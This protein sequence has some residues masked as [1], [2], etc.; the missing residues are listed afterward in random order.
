MGQ[1]SNVKNM[2]KYFDGKLSRGFVSIYSS[3]I[4]L[5]ISVA[6]LGLFLPIFMFELFGFSLKYVLIYYL[7]DYIIYGLIVAPGAKISLNKIG[8]KKSIIIS[9]FF[10]MI[11]YFLF[12][13]VDKFA[14]VGN[15]NWFSGVDREKIIIFA[16]LTI[17]IINIRRV[18]Y[19]VPIHTDL[20]KFTDRK[21]RLKQ[22]SL[23]EASTI[24]LNAV[25]PAIAGWILFYYNYDIL[26]IM[27]IFVYLISLIPLITLPETSEK[28]SWTYL[29][30]LKEFFSKKRRKTV[31][32]FAGDGAENVI[33]G[34]IWPIFM[35]Q[36]LKGNY[37]YLGLLS[38][39]IVVVSVVL[40]LFVGKLG[41]RGKNKNK[42]FKIGIIF[43]AFGWIVKI[44]I[45]TAFQIF[46]TSTYHNLTRVFTRAPFDALNYEKA[47]DQG[48]FVDEYT[49]I[50]EMALMAG[51]VFIIIIMLIL[52]PFISIQWM[53][54]LGAISALL[55]N[56]MIN[57]EL[58]EEGRHD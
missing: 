4:I 11:Y 39:L 57:D 9:T 47:A 37:L 21:N 56:F 54:I 13:M 26:F 17:I 52:I 16:I 55:M 6:L 15:E 12:F 46:I 8:I 7:I 50:H 36:I 42:V 1:C 31:I 34:I 10:G 43:Y 28:Y 33:S 35:W 58:L 3:R 38:S 2:I 24:A 25:M 5:R 40:Q 51:R 30:T 14:K 29:E 27:V 32:A 49:V 22:L 18:I 45:E 19:W 20:T 48:H 23:L 53:F 44:F 41:D